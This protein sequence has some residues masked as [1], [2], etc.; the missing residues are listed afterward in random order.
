MAQAQPQLQPGN[1]LYPVT[2]WSWTISV[3]N[4][5]V[6]TSWLQRSCDY[7]AAY[8]IAGAFSLEAGGRHAR[9]HVQG[10]L[11]IRM[12]A[13]AT[14]ESSLRN[15]VKSFIPILRGS[16]GHVA[17]KPL[18]HGQTWD[19]MLGYVQKDTGTAHYR[20]LKHNVSDEDLERGRIAYAGVRNDPTDGRI[21][22][23]KGN[24][25]KLA[26]R[27][28]KTHLTPLQVPLD[29]VLKYMMQS[30]M[31]IPSAQWLMAA[32]GK[33]MDNDRSQ[34]L[35]DVLHQDM[36][37]TTIRQVRQIF[38]D[39]CNPRHGVDEQWTAS[40]QQVL[41]QARELREANPQQPTHQAHAPSN[42]LMDQAGAG[43]STS[44]I[45]PNQVRTP[46]QRLLD[47]LRR[48]EE[49]FQQQAAARRERQRLLARIR[50]SSD[51]DSE[52]EGYD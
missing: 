19:Y 16:A 33:G 12:E 45:D 2:E 43:P 8:G 4:G 23:N 48:A 26:V 34:A 17:I 24:V 27:F 37:N 28:W 20:M 1:T 18:Q 49:E 31:Y 50:D 32:Y 38:F 29:H 22:I 3:R 11:R 44:F 42:H 39:N 7:A 51:D 25:F 9:L 13:T 5:H 47:T 46:S 40:L 41:T 15:H 14:G 35:F 36:A 10:V 30:D 6:P 21:T 52:A